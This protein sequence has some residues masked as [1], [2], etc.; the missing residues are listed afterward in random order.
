MSAVPVQAIPATNFAPST[1]DDWARSDVY[2]NKYLLK[3]DEALEA[4]LE[5]STKNGLPPIS[6]SK[7]QGK[8][9][10]LL[11]QSLGAKR[12]LE[13]GTLGG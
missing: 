12:I 11:I 9:L 1:I 7:A 13:V 4:A 10:K 3:S 2:H 5:N 6:V 8:Y